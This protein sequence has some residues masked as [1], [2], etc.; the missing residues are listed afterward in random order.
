MHRV[1][2]VFRMPQLMIIDGIPVT[3]EERNK[4]DM[5]FADQLPVSLSYSFTKVSFIIVCDLSV[6]IMSDWS[7]NI[8]VQFNP[9]CSQ[10]NVRV[11]KPL[12]VFLCH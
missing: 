9:L 6:S 12:Q 7:V 8:P 4:A 11:L 5:Y 10:L 1:V 2:L 3:D